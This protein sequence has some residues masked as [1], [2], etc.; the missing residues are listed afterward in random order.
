MHALRG[1]GLVEAP[2]VVVHLGEA[3][4]HVVLGAALPHRPEAEAQR[5]VVQLRRWKRRG[6]E[7]FV[8]KRQAEE[9]EEEASETELISHSSQP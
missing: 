7:A 1:G 2:H 4:L 8:A 3:L 9:E 6:K 5:R